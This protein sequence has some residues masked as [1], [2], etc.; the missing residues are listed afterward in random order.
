MG[1]SWSVAC[2]CVQ[3]DVGRPSPR[4][5]RQWLPEARPAPH[6]L[7]LSVCAHGNPEVLCVP[8]N[9]AAS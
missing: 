3:R 8:C 4:A 7:L 5:S 2:H 9:S 6:L 1:A